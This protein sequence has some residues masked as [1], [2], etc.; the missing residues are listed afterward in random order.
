MPGPFSRRQSAEGE[1]RRC[2]RIA[3]TDANS[4]WECRSMADLAPYRGVDA[5]RMVYVVVKQSGATLAQYGSAEPRKRFA[6]S[7][8]LARFRQGK[9]ISGSVPADVRR[10]F[11]R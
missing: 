4:G 11:T 5:T 1:A 6:S 9:F 3:K 10:S 8:C 7:R 2:R